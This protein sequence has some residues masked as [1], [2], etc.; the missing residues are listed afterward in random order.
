MKKSIKP[1]INYIQ[2][3]LEVIE[4]NQPESLDQLNT[5][6]NLFDASLMRLQAIGEQLT[7][8]RH[9]FPETYEEHA[10]ESWHKLI[11]L[12]N[13]ISHGYFDIESEIIWEILDIY[14]SDFKKTVQ[15]IES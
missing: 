14:L 1:H 9:N 11:G 10:D 4:D 6:R 13:I 12:R 15:K 5:D 2:E 7:Q 3:L 8:I